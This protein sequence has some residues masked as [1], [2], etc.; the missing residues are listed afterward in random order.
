LINLVFNEKYK[1]ENIEKYWS[2]FG[3]R[4]LGKNEV[5]L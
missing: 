1:K 4:N 3:S 2:Y 5:Y